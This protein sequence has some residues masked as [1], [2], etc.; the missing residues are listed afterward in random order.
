[1]LPV[2]S[3]LALSGAVLFSGIQ[4][5]PAL[6]AATVLE[7]GEEF[8]GG[9]ATSTMSTGNEKA[10]SHFSPNIGFEGELDFK[11]GNSIFRKEW[12]PSPASAPSSDG[13]GPLYNARSCEAC[14]IRDGRGHPPAANWPDDNAVSMFLRLS[15]PPQNKRQRRLVTSHRAAIIP[16]PTYGGQLQDI[17]IQ[18][19][20]GE[21]HMHVTYEDMP[22]TLK[23][24]M[25]IILRKP[26]YSITDLGYGPLHPD[27]LLSPRVTP[28]MI[29]LGLLEAISEEAILA[30]EDAEDKDGDGI[31]GRPN[32][33][34]SKAENRVSLGRFGWKAG[35]PS[36]LDQTAMAFAADIGISSRLVRLPSGDCTDGQKLCLD[37]PNG[38][39]EGEEEVNRQLLHLITRYSRNLAV[40]KR[41]NAK[42]PD[43]LAGRKIFTLLGCIACHTP[44]HVTGVHAQEPH[45]S[46]QKIW[47]YTDLLLHDMGEGLADNR[48]E[49]VAN[50]TEWRTAPLWGVGLT[51]RVSGHSFF[52]HDGRARNLTEAILWHG[53]EA[54]NARDRFI[55]LSGEERERLLTFVKSL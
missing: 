15:I 28:Q 49:G 23:G 41:R 26:S 40:P 14:H 55:A 54:Q 35:A 46:M 16:E 53:G 33:V 52:L 31:S 19:H 34:W 3:A 39:S 12:M 9:G 4:S 48:P 2:I 11:I 44:S 13:L 50:G 7:P 45:L 32:W 10:F 30:L 43:V 24:G 27:T 51:Q 25:T 6:Q 5:G 21:G 38:R 20:A 1:M 18:G 22:V 17:A 8:P 42:D 37:A 47:P 36:V 29:G